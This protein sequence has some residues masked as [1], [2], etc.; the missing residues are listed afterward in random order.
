MFRKK[1]YIKFYRTF[2]GR[3][4]VL[5]VIF[6]SVIMVIV[7]IAS[8]QFYYS[9]LRNA[10]DNSNRDYV[11]NYA[12]N[13]TI[14]MQKII[15]YNNEFL[16]NKENNQYI[17]DFIQYRATD[18]YMSRVMERNLKQGMTNLMQLNQGIIGMQLVMKDYR[19]TTGSVVFEFETHSEK[20]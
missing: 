1:G 6:L 20:Y 17:Q 16:V 8:C 4:T 15:T 19:I 5:T 9:M 2:S 13:L 10:L 14:M 11:E 18:N 3:I 7:A 12:N